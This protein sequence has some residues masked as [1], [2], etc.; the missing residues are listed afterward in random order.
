MMAAPPQI[1]AEDFQPSAVTN[2]FWLRW[3]IANVGSLAPFI[4]T[5]GGVTSKIDA[6]VGSSCDPSVR[7]P[8]V[9]C[10]GSEGDALSLTARDWYGTPAASH[11]AGLVMPARV[12]AAAIFACWLAR[13]LGG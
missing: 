8:E 3:E 2:S 13:K 4:M 7:T 6:P 1:M 10:A 12:S 9:E 5:T 11:A